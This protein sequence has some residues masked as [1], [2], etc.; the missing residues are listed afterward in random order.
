LGPHT[1][2]ES[3]HMRDARTVLRLTPN[4]T[5]PKRSGPSQPSQSQAAGHRHAGDPGDCEAGTRTERRA[6]SG[7]L[8]VHDRYRA[9]GDPPV[10]PT[11]PALRTLLKTRWKWVSW[12]FDSLRPGRRRTCAAIIELVVDL[13][14]GMDQ[15]WRPIEPSAAARSTARC[16]APSTWPAGTRPSIGI[17]SAC[18]PPP[19]R[20][21]FG[22]GVL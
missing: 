15:S 21:L 2:G 13:P 10:G 8:Y 17:P 20:S 16:R 9:A 7:G 19:D 4:G 3:Y 5:T 6:R 18:T 11:W 22:G 12:C 14:C 1:D